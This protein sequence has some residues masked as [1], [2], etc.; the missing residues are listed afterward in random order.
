MKLWLD[1]IITNS[2]NITYFAVGAAIVWGI[3]YCTIYGKDFAAG[4]LTAIGIVYGIGA[5]RAGNQAYQDAKVEVAKVKS[6]TD[7]E[8]VP[9]GD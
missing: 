1:W 5:A 3:F 9:S 2:K 4:V 6:K 7:I 8:N